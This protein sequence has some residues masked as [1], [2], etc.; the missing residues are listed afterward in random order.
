[1]RYMTRCILYVSSAKGLM[2]IAK[3]ILEYPQTLR[4]V[5]W[6]INN[7]KMVD[8]QIVTLLFFDWI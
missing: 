6:V 8:Y 5:Y 2:K 1:M 3:G 4:L 7:Y